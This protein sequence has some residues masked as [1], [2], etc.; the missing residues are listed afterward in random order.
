MSE[1]HELEAQ[2]LNLKISSNSLLE[3]ATF[4]A[5]RQTSDAYVIESIIG[6]YHLPNWHHKL[7]QCYNLPVPT[8][9]NMKSFL[10]KVYGNLKCRKYKKPSM[11]TPFEPEP[12]TSTTSTIIASTAD[13]AAA[14]TATVQAFQA[15]ASDI[16]VSVQLSPSH[17]LG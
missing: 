6:G 5:L 15:T 2:G 16:T 1:S 9:S 17:R 3:W 12:L 11:T 10:K 13:P 8:F 4:D 7:Q 14:A